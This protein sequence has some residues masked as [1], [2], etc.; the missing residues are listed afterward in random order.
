MTVRELLATYPALFA[1]Q[2]WY[3]AEP[4]MDLPLHRA[5]RVPSGASCD[6]I[7]PENFIDEVQELQ[8]VT[9]LLTAY[10]TD[11]TA[12][13]WDRYLWT[14]TRDHLGQRIYVGKNN[15]LMEI[16]RHLHLTNR[17]GVPYWEKA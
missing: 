11:P 10:I 12:A 13:L 4:F 17:W 5:L 9:D 14:R 7:P 8:T 2:T 16:H 6:G 15:G 3:Q 1:A